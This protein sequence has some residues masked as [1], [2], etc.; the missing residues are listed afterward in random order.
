M[1][2]IRRALTAYFATFH[3]K[4]HEGQEGYEGREDIGEPRVC[5]ISEAIQIDR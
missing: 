2:P 4:G 1:L 3:A 5:E